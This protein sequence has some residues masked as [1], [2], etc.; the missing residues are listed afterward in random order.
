MLNNTVGTTDHRIN[1]EIDLV[2]SSVSPQSLLFFCSSNITPDVLVE[3]KK[4][5]ELAKKSN[6]QFVV[7]D[8]SSIY[9]KLCQR[10]NVVTNV[11]TE[12]FPPRTM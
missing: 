5:E 10:E 9:Y 2:R 4:A 1:S 8:C 12:E 11:Q 3:M 7:V 6:L